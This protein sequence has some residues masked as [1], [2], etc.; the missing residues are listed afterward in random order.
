[1]KRRIKL[2]SFFVTLFGLTQLLQ[3]DL[4]ESCRS[5][6][7][8]MY[9]ATLADS[10]T[11][12]L[13]KLWM[14]AFPVRVVAA[15][16]PCYFGGRHNGLRSI[17]LNLENIKE[18]TDPKSLCV[19]THEFMHYKHAHFAK[20]LIIAPLIGLT[21]IASGF[22]A[23]Y[24]LTKY[25]DSLRMRYGKHLSSSNRLVRFCAQALDKIAIVSTALIPLAVVCTSFI[26]MSRA[27]SHFFELQ[28]DTA[29][30]HMTKEFSEMIEWRLA[31]K[32]GPYSNKSEEIFMKL[33]YPSPETLARNIERAAAHASDSRSL[34]SSI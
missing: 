17:E 6:I 26:G 4:L 25:G 29:T 13:T 9:Q 28:A 23:A 18:S 34:T 16:Q 15:A 14:R 1:M 7:N 5:T 10:Q 19:M 27:L 20:G 31:N 12:W 24:Y 22:F 2:F 8:G 32:W 30:A 3:A 21:S 11:P 33:T